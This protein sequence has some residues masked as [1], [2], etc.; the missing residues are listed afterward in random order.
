MLTKYVK[1]LKAKK[2]SQRKRDVVEIR[3]HFNRLF[4]EGS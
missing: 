3:C 2:K 4:E 1:P